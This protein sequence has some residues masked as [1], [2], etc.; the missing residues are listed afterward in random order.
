MDR[1]SQLIE[2]LK[3]GRSGCECSKALPG[4]GHVHCPSHEDTKPSFSVSEKDRKTL[5]HC[6]AGCSQDVVVSALQEKGLWPKGP[7]KKSSNPETRYQVR[8][9]DGHVIAVHVRYEGIKNGTIPSVRI[10][11]RKILIPEDAL[12]RLLQGHQDE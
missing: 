6:Q 1:I 2:A 11:K 5:V 4:K 3:C 7:V 8:E 12:E 10:S 9:S